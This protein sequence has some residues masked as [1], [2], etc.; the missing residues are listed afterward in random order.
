M[1]QLAQAYILDDHVA[2]NEAFA[3][4]CH[5]T[6]DLHMTQCC[7]I[8]KIG[9]S[10]THAHP[11]RQA[12]AFIAS[13]SKHYDA[14]Y[15]QQRKKISH[16]SAKAHAVYMIAVERHPYTVLQTNCACTV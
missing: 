2:Q 4:K 9:K 10:Y 5:L 11:S 3:P 6:S 12:N 1:P 8:G 16:Q 15:A 14:K 13:A 7:Q